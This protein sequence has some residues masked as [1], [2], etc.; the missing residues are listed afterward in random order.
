MADFIDLTL[1]ID[2]SGDTTGEEAQRHAASLSAVLSERLEVA[3][4]AH[5]TLPAPTAAKAGSEIAVIGAMLLQ[6]APTAI[7]PVLK[8]VRE[9]LTRPGALP[10]KITVKRNGGEVAVEFDPRQTSTSDIASLAKTLVG[11]V[12]GE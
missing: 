9:V 3:R 12:D 2:S 5:C 4:L 10:T 1:V 7:E 8:M 6:L 11:H